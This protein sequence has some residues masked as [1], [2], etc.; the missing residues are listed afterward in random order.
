MY[1]TLTSTEEME[2]IDGL[3]CRIWTGET[4]SSLPVQAAIVRIAPD[5]DA[6]G[7][8]RAEFTNEC[9]ASGFIPPGATRQ[10]VAHDE[11]PDR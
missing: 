9:I 10:K 1:I 7:R 4:A 11:R 5:M 6:T 2:T 3:P 8:E